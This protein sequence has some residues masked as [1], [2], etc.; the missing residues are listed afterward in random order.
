MCEITLSLQVLPWQDNYSP[1]THKLAQPATVY[2][3][4]TQETLFN[5][6]QSGGE[7]RCEQDV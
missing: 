1:K 2:F 7:D 6:A 4:H 3:Q 5:I